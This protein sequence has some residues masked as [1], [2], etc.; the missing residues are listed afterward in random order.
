MFNYF[1]MAATLSDPC[2]IYSA[3][4]QPW[5][6]T[7]ASIPMV[8]D[9][10]FNWTGWYRLL[11]N[12]MNVRMPESCVNEYRCGTDIPLWLNGSH[13]QI[14]DGIVTRGVC[15]SWASNC[16]YYSSTSIRVKA[17]PENYYVYEFVRPTVCYSAYC[18]GTVL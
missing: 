3:L 5:R 11:Y 6:G 18:A 10:Y 14:Q 16:S 8:C 4:D 1:P 7:N 12:G 2:N 13:P 15:G 9:S 17:C